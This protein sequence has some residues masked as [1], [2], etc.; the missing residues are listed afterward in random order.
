[1]ENGKIEYYEEDIIFGNNRF[2]HYFLHQGLR[3]DE[4]KSVLASGDNHRSA[5]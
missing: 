1:M 5:I 3:R 4:Q 2:D